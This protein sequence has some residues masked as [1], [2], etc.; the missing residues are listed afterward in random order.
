MALLARNIET[1][2]VRGIP[3]RKSGQSFLG[4]VGRTTGA[5]QAKAVDFVEVGEVDAVHRSEK[6]F[7]ADHV[8]RFAHFTSSAAGSLLSV[9]PGLLGY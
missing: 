8:L 2:R 4:R 7:F 6:P 3:R 9:L 5:A 1:M